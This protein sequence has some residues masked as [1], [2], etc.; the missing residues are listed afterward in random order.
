MI[1]STDLDAFGYYDSPVQEPQLSPLKMTKAFSK[2]MQQNLD[3]QVAAG[4]IMEEYMEWWDAT[5]PEE[6]LKELA[7]LVYVVYGYAN[8]KGWDLDEAVRRVHKSNMSKLDEE[9]K[10]IRREDGKILKGPR[11]KKPDLGDLV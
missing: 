2:A 9:G 11:Y 1:N 10:P 7:D 6:E 8:V 3:P 5:S 4:L